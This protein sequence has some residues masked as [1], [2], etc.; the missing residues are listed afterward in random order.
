MN[1]RSTLLVAAL[2]FCVIFAASATPPSLIGQVANDL[3]INPESVAASGL[4]SSASTILANLTATQQSC[5]LLAS[6]R[7]QLGIV[8]NNLTQLKDSL[9]ENPQDESLKAQ[10]QAAQAQVNQ[11]RQQIRETK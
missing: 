6:Q 4:A 3:A 7:Q 1:T 11:L 9:Q 5:E 10:V 8:T 2:T